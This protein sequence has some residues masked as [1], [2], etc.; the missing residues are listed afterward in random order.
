MHYKAGELEV[1]AL[2]LVVVLVGVIV[3]ALILAFKL[4]KNE[5]EEE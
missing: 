3:G 2:I 5:E 1:P 4:D